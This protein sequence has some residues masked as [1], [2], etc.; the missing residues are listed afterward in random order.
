MRRRLV[1]AYAD[2]SVYGG[3][4]DE[5]FETASLAFFEE[6]CAGKRHLVVSEIV[7]REITAA[8]EAVRL[9]FDERLADAEI[10]AVTPEVLK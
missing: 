9:L 10:A 1:R 7:R 4:Y 5:E 2:T 6:V 8:P 3:V